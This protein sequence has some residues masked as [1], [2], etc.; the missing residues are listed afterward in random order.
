LAYVSS[1]SENKGQE[2]LAQELVSYSQLALLQS[3]VD[4]P[5]TICFAG[6]SKSEKA[7][8]STLDILASLGITG[9][10]LGL[11]TL[12]EQIVLFAHAGKSMLLT[13]S[14][15][16]PRV[17]YLSLA[18]GARVLTTDR[19]AVASPVIDNDCLVTELPFFDNSTT[20]SER[21]NKIR[22]FLTKDDE[23]GGTNN[24]QTTLSKAYGILR[25][26]LQYGPIVRRAL[27]M[28][29][30]LNFAN[31]GNDDCLD[32]FAVECEQYRKQNKQ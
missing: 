30:N 1:W 6:S 14:D 28:W 4:P 21:A 8:K 13:R 18:S 25:E 5:L 9:H 24:N 27:K 10:D 22:Q 2:R 26:S 20:V 15:H 17:V 31:E 12:E 11:L 3:L 23:C 16:S 29:R 7:V 19:A 32:L